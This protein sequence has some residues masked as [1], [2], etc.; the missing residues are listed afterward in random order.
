MKG[1]FARYPAGAEPLDQG[2]AQLS[3]SGRLIEGINEPLEFRVLGYLAYTSTPAENA[4]G[5]VLDGG[6]QGGTVLIRLGKN[7]VES[8]G[9]NL[10]GGPGVKTG[11]AGDNLSGLILNTFFRQ[12]HI[13]F[14]N[15][16]PASPSSI[17]YRPS[18][19]KCSYCRL[20]ITGS[21]FK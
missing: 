8:G 12:H 18:H 5:S 17:N 16:H 2:L 21:P 9:E 3:E 6:S 14:H 15:R 4:R 13:T 7:K 19:F 1:G 10:E 20:I 11:E